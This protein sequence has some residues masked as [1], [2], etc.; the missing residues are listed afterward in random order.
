MQYILTSLDKYGF[1]IWSVLSAKRLAGFFK[2]EARKTLS[3]LHAITLCTSYKSR[4]STMLMVLLINFL[5]LLSFHY[6]KLFFFMVQ[7]KS[8]C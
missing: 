1:I 2:W 5:V 4:L 7:G 8:S 3:C 6:E